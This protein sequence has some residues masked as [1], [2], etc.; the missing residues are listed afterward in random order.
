MRAEVASTKGKYNAAIIK[1][2]DVKANLVATRQEKI[3]E[4][5]RLQVELAFTRQAHDVEK[6]NAEH[7]RTQVKLLRTEKE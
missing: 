5:K 3:E 7:I 4:N 1:D 6:Q 2:R